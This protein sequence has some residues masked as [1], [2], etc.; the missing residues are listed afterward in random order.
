MRVLASTALMS[1]SRCRV[2]GALCGQIAQR[3]FRDVADVSLAAVQRVDLLRVQVVADHP[4][5]RAGEHLGERQPDVAEA[6]DPHRG[7]AP[8]DPAQEA[9]QRLRRRRVRFGCTRRDVMLGHL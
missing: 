3:L 1:G 2:R 5:A 6:H 8:F 4:E 7:R 9:V